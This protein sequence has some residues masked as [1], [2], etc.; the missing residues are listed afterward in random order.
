M[1]FYVTMR[2]TENFIL[3][4]RAY[5]VMFKLVSIILIITFAFSGVVL[6][7]QKSR[8]FWTEFDVI[9]FQTFPFAVLMG[10]LADRGLSALIWP[11]SPPH[12]NEVLIFATVISVGNAFDHAWRV[13]KAAT[14]EAVGETSL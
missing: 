13:S 12:W 11:G 8:N 10:Y 2:G 5:R 4:F 14:S 3:R 6:A 7:E 9:L 1:R